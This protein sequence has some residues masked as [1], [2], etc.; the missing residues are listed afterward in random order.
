M[1][2]AAA[3]PDRGLSGALA[4]QTVHLHFQ[5]LGQPFIITV[6]ESHPFAKGSLDTSVACPR[7]ALIDLTAQD[8]KAPVTELPEDTL[9]VIRRPIIYYDQ[10]MVCE[11]LRQHASDSSPEQ[12]SSIVGWHHHTHARRS[13]T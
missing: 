13:S 4:R 5:P 7:R 10:L 8:P 3:V 12:L 9:R 1:D 11:S 6:Q 2:L